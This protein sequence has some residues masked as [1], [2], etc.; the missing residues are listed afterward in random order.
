VDLVDYKKN[1]YDLYNILGITFYIPTNEY[2][3]KLHDLDFSIGDNYKNYK[4]LYSNVNGLTHEHNPVYDLHM[5]INMYIK[6][7]LKLKKNKL[8]KIDSLIKYFT[9]LDLIPK[10][11][12]GETNLY[13]NKYR[14]TD[15]INKINNYIPKDMLSPIE[16]LLYSDKFN[17]FKIKPKHPYK[18]RH[19][20]NAKIKNSDNV[21]LSRT[22]MFNVYL[23]KEL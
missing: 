21:L 10:N 18:I 19:T 5:Y 22:D 1:E 11:T 12:L 14:L 13:S 8:D 4:I 16:L 23:R 3:I 6:L 15:T 9:S 20:Y 7:L 17:M 2:V